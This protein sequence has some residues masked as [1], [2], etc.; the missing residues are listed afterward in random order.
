MKIAFP[1]VRSRSGS[2]VY[3]ENLMTGLRDHGMECQHI[4]LT[5][6]H[7]FIPHLTAEQRR[8]IDGADIIHTA[9]EH[10]CIVHTLGRPLILSALHNVL[11]PEYQRY[12]SLLQKLYHH[13][14][15]HPRQ[16]RSLALADKVICIS[17]YTKQSYVEMYPEYADK[18]VT[19][20]PGIDL[21]KFK[22]G[23][24]ELTRKI[25][26][27][28]KTKHHILFVGHLTRRKGADLLPKIMD[29][30]GPDYTLTCIGQRNTRESNSTTPS[31]A[32]IIIK[33]PVSEEELIAFYQ[34]CDLLLFPSRLEGFGY[35]V[36]EA[37][38]CGKPVVTTL[39]HS[40]PELID[41]ESGGLLCPPNDYRCFA[42]SLQQIVGD[43]TLLLQMG[44]HNRVKTRRLFNIETAAL[45]YGEI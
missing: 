45:E 35:A 1:I 16:R 18:L 6:K 3:F 17:N 34:A 2:D 37:M 44:S 20:Y 15:I 24:S 32:R 42:M 41:Q 19:I 33:R 39:A 26:S 23:E 4:P 25:K 14:I 7:E 30:L 31:G 28:I 10:G 29:L 13:L 38:A 21:E 43:S 5:H 8:T 9:V 12:T 11:D 40:M 22:P 27:A 36:A